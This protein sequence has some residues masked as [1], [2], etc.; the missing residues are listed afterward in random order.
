MKTRQELILDFMLVMSPR[1]FDIDCL[2]DETK[3]TIIKNAAELLV[4][5]YLEDLV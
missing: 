5:K 2:D 3:A 4:N 1:I